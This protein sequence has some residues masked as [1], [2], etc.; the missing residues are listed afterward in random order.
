MI[1][2]AWRPHVPR[3]L[4]DRQVATQLEVR[5]ADL[6]AAGLVGALVAL[7]QLGP[8]RDA[9]GGPLMARLEPCGSKAKGLW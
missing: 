4:A 2:P 6:P 7:S 1:S 5:A 3:S 9:P 8:W